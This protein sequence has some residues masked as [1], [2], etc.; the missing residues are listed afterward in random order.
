[1]ADDKQL[2]RVNVVLNKCLKIIKPKGINE[3]VDGYMKRFENIKPEEVGKYQGEFNKSY[4]VIIGKIEDHLAQD[5]L[6]LGKAGFYKEGVTSE[7][8]QMFLINVKSNSLE[9]Y[10]QLRKNGLSKKEAFEEA[11][12]MYKDI[13]R[14]IWESKKNVGFG[15]LF[16]S[17]VDDSPE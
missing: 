2:K 11:T 13:V 7:R 12:D 8:V 10:A 4:D 16:R 14:S 5:I 15:E 6:T 3:I 17:Y 1:M 9:K